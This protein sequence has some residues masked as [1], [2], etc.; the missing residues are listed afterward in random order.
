[1]LSLL[2]FGQNQK[3][4]ILICCLL[5][6]V[7]CGFALFHGKL[8]KRG[9]EAILLAYGLY[10]LWLSLGVLWACS[11]KLFLRE[12][13]KQLFALPLVLF[14]FLLL[15]R[16]ESAVRRLLFFLS[17]V[18]AV[19]A[20]FSIDVASAGLT[21]GLL[22]LIPNFEYAITGFESGTRLTSVFRNGNISAGL[23]AICIFMSLYLIESAENR[24]ERIFATVFIALQ[25]NTFLLNFSLGATAFFMLSVIVYLIFAGKQRAGV[26]L[27]MLEIAIPTVI[28]V[29]LS[30]RFFEALDGRAALPVFAAIVNAAVIVLLELKVYPRMVQALDRRKKAVTILFVAVLLIICVYGAA[31][32]I[33]RGELELPNKG[34][35]RRS[36][37]PTGGEYTVSI[38]AD[39]EFRLRIVSQDER[40][41]I[42]HTETQL[43]SG[44]E[45]TVSITVP[46]DSLVVYLTFSSKKGATLHSVTL[47][48]P[49][50]ISLHL[51][52]PL[53]PG[54][55]ANR[56]QGLKA[57]ENAIQR[58]AF[59]RDGMKVFRD[60][61]ILGGGLGSFETLLFGYQ[62]FYYETKYVHNHYIQ[63]MLDSGVIGIILYL[64][65]L[66]LMAISLWVWR[67]KE[68]PFSRLYPALCAA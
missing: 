55:I 48:G 67:K 50:T 53:L 64:S 7:I 8:Q 18:G 28:T 23:L 32:I 9:R 62:N 1:M 51:G 66:V 35:I 19:Y 21:K 12:F 57:N 52:Y 39:G 47:T 63:V 42:M 41:T 20:F 10:L 33:M 25:A 44:T 11:G 43:Y 16:R 2:Q 40:E 4:L 45:S 46:E 5:S 24:R 14:I 56:L 3:W 31:G 27:R 54:F 65:L 17:A 13:S 15:P 60:R 30:F 37:Y 34:E 38:D 61:P 49:E 29:F 26:L 36:C 58:A 68:G 22:Y 6:A 59:F